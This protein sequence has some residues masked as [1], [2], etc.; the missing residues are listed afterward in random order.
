[1]MELSGQLDK[2]NQEL[3]VAG[4][5][6]EK[7]QYQISEKKDQIAQTEKELDAARRVMSKRMHNNYKYGNVTLM[8]VLLSSTS[9]HDLV[10]RVYF[11]D[12]ISEADSRTVDKVVALHQRLNGEKAQLEEK[13]NSQ[14]AL[15][16]E[17]NK[18]VKDY[19]DKTAEAR[20]YYS[21]L[22]SQL[23][24]DIRRKAEA[25]QSKAVMTITGSAS[26]SRSDSGSTSNGNSSSSSAGNSTSTS[27]ANS[28]SSSSNSSSGGSHGSIIIPVAPPKPK[29]SPSG[30]GLA[31]AY[32]L[33]G[34]PYVWGATGPN[35]FDCSGLVNYCFGGAYGRTTYD[36]IAAAKRA[37]RWKTS[38]SQMRPGDILFPSTHHVGIYIGNNQ[39]IHA[40][41]PGDHVKIS[42]VYG[43]IGGFTY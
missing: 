22:D 42:V 32:K 5:N 1:M 17:V 41:K 9:F 35:A 12:K 40:P 4:N 6:L 7:T 2:L 18:Q 8:Q 15:L 25:Q 10:S 26:D 21:K 23:Q 3:T 33:I 37:G 24:E 20:A 27:S 36:M 16:D 34:A 38:M 39:F 28:T 19:Q 11:M 14:K 31:T 43:F 29:P 13:Q 30:G